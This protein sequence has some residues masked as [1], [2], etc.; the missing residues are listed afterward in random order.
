MLLR[1]RVNVRQAALV[2]STITAET[3]QLYYLRVT[4][5]SYTVRRIK[6][7]EQVVLDEACTVQLESPHGESTRVRVLEVVVR[8]NAGRSHDGA[9]HER[10]NMLLH[11]T[12]EYE[13]V[14]A[15][16]EMS[17]NINPGGQAVDGS[18]M[19]MAMQVLMFSLLDNAVWSGRRLR[20]VALRLHI[21]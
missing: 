7:S 18:A 17:R 15:E 5:S 2:Q 14:Q 8:H 3:E 6:C 16:M 19:I 10:S 21:V 12:V 4:T 9:S 1:S 13:R 11:R 20:Q